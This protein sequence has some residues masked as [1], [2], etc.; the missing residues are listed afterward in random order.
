MFI[1]HTASGYHSATG[2]VLSL[3]VGEIVYDYSGGCTDYFY[4]GYGNGNYLTNDG[5][6]ITITNEFITSIYTC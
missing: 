6:I 2:K 3:N 5:K 1:N 4:G